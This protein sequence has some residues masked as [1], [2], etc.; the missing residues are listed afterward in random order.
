MATLTLGE[1]SPSITER[2]QMAQ[3][4]FGYFSEK[5]KNSQ[6]FKKSPKIVTQVIFAP[7]SSNVYAKIGFKAIA[8]RLE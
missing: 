3:H 5:K 6:Y 1:K 8:K 2:N 4:F 7:S